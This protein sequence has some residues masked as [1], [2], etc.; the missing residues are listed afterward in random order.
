MKNTNA[1]YDRIGKTYDVTRHA[2]SEIVARLHEML[3]PVAGGRYLDVGCGSGNYTCALAAK[4]LQ[5]TGIDVSE[6]MLQKARCKSSQVIWFQGDAKQLPFANQIFQGAICTLAT[7]HIKPL[8]AA[9]HEIFRVLENGKLVIFTATPEQMQHYWLWHYFPKMMRTGSEHMLSFTAIAEL[10]QDAGFLDVTG[11]PFFV[12]NQLQDL[13]LQSGKYRPEIYLDT[14]VRAGISSFAA[15]AH[16]DEIKDGLVE[17][18]NDIHTG[19]INKIIEPYESTE[20]DYMFVA[21]TKR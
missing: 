9:L 11:S 13:F 14:A 17:L 12:T 1:V 8:Q 3:S 19:K 20:G 10:L 5:M 4:G 16:A 2:D 6:E 21:A 15:L 7:H 18:E